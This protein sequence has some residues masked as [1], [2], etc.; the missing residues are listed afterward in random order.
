MIGDRRPGRTSSWRDARSQEEDSRTSGASSP[1]G[2]QDG[3]AIQQ[4]RVPEHAGAAASSCGTRYI[5]T[6]CEMIDKTDLAAAR[7]LLAAYLAQVK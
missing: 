7:D 2:G 6:V 5:H 1:R 4:V 3:A